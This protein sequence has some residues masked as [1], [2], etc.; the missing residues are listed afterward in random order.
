VLR[1]TR[2]RTFI[3]FFPPCTRCVVTHKRSHII[4]KCYRDNAVRTHR[5]EDQ[6][7]CNDSTLERKKLY[8]FFSTIKIWNSYVAST[9][10]TNSPTGTR[11]RR[12]RDGRNPILHCCYNT[13]RYY[14][15]CNVRVRGYFVNI[16]NKPAWA[17]V[18]RIRR[19]NHPTI[20]R[21]SCDF[22]GGANE[23]LFF[24]FFFMETLFLHHILGAATRIIEWPRAQVVMVNGVRLPEH[25]STAAQYGFRGDQYSC[26]TQLFFILFPRHIHMTFS[27]YFNCKSAISR[28]SHR[29]LVRNVIVLLHYSDAL[30]QSNGECFQ[31]SECENIW[32]L[33][34]TTGKG[35]IWPHRIAMGVQRARMIPVCLCKCAF[36][37]LDKHVHLRR[38][39][40]KPI[41]QYDTTCRIHV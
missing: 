36:L 21:R 10:K 7:F 25:R 4:V 29:D 40:V 37:I 5:D 24:F 30:A 9:R 41:H 11:R 27:I 15:C 14:I 1:T 16:F 22:S 34:E 38:T 28:I 32:P 35:Y 12:L 17:I 18:Q 8:F 2:A 26:R 39:E 31:T 23:W 33:I 13:S 19:C 20:I 6:R 3:Y